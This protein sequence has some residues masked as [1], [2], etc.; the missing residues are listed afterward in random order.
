MATTERAGH[1]GRGASAR[2]AGVSLPPDRRGRCAPRLGGERRLP[3]KVEED[4]LLAFARGDEEAGPVV[5]R[6]D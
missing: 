5:D 2:C 6:L 4:G 1:G 3:D